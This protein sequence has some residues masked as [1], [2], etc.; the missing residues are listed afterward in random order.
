M[1]VRPLL[2]TSI[3]IVLQVSAHV[4]AQ[5]NQPISIRVVDDRG[6]AVAGAEVRA[7]Y[8]ATVRQGK[9]DFQVA[10]ELAPP[11]KTDE[12]GNC[13]LAPNDASWSLAAVRAFRTA[14]TTD[15][16]IRRH[17]EAPTDPV[18]KK[19]FMRKLDD[20][21]LHYSSACRVLDPD[22][23]EEPII[24]QME[25]AIK[26]SGRLLVDGQPLAKAFV[27]I[28]SRKTAI[29]QLFPR[30]SPELTDGSGEFSFYAIPAEL[31]QVRVLVE[32]PS[33]NRVLEVDRFPFKETKEGRTYMI[34]TK[35]KDYKLVDG[36]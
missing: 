8:L 32:R 19:A 6:K 12:K 4:S 16:V 33:G 24:L 15:E 26:L 22:A 7:R 34:E 36:A 2:L 28:S 13:I 25:K 3:V 9:K 23:I 20:E 35:A 31:D 27:T 11:Q 10:V 18:A 30:S 14:M 1:Y 29:D 5:S 17:E 21:Q